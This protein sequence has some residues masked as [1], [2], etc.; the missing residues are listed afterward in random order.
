MRPLKDKTATE[1]VQVMK[2]ILDEL[3]CLETNIQFD[4]GEEFRINIFKELMKQ[5][6]INHYQTFLTVKSQLLRQNQELL[7]N[8]FKKHHFCPMGSHPL[9]F[10]LHV[11]IEKKNV[12]NVFIKWKLQVQVRLR[13][14]NT[15]S[16][17]L[18]KRFF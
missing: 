18:Y 1:V 6:N 12:E 7:H 4:L 13:S 17:L 16:T 10:Q 15:Y 2:S 11:K 5:Y 14:F 3:L 9:L 8:F